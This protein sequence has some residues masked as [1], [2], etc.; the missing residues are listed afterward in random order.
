M[1][2]DKIIQKAIEEIESPAWGQEN[3]ILYAD[4]HLFPGYDQMGQ[5]Q[6][7]H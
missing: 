2:E 6:T 4:V 3:Q 7:R 5:N 1:S